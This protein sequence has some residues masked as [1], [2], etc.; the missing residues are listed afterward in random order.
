MRDSSPGQPDN[1]DASEFSEADNDAESERLLERHQIL[2]DQLFE[3]IAAERKVIA[4]AV[5]AEDVLDQLLEL[6][7]QE[8]TL[9]KNLRRVARRVALCLKRT[10]QPQR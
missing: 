3:L 2:S 8:V 7:L 5:S 6:A 4:D 9:I 1:Q 10:Q